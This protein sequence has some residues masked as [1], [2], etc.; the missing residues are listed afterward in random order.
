MKMDMD[1]IRD[2]LIYFENTLKV[3]GDFELASSIRIPEYTNEQ[4]MYHIPLLIDGGYI[5][6]INI[7]TMYERDFWIKRLTLDGHQLLELIKNDTFWNHV[8]DAFEKIGLETIPTVIPIVAPRILN[9]L[10]LS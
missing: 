4:I 7:G 10:G 5:E 2:L 3:G 1:L 6:V 8:K 9:M